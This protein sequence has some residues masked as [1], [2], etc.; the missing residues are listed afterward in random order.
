[1]SISVLSDAS[2]ARLPSDKI[3]VYFIIM[4][5]ASVVLFCLYYMLALSI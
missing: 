2:P 5:I 1:M 3:F 4:K